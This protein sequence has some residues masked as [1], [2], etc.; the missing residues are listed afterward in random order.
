MVTSAFKNIIDSFIE[1]VKNIHAFNKEQYDAELETL[2]QQLR[3]E[4]DALQLEHPLLTAYNRKVFERNP[5]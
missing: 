2:K 4:L 1:K 5:S 3:E